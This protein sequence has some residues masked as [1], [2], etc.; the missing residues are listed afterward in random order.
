MPN[1]TNTS[2]AGPD[3]HRRSGISAALVV[4]HCPPQDGTFGYEGLTRCRCH[5]EA[6]W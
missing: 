3:L 4:A 5:A 1:R 6:S 2:I